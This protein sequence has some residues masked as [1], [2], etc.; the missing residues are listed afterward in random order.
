VTNVSDAGPGSLRAAVAAN[1]DT[2]PDPDTIN[3]A[4][5]LTG[6]TIRLTSGQL[7]LTNTTGPL[8]IEELSGGPPVISGE[9]ASRVF[10]V[11]SG[12]MAEILD[13]TI[14]GG[15]T[16]AGGISNRGT[17]TV[18]SCTLSG[19]RCGS[20]L[21]G[22]GVF[23]SGSLTVT[24]STFSGNISGV[25]GGGIFNDSNGR[26]TVTDSTLSG[27][28]VTNF[29]GGGGGIINSFSATMTIT[30]STITGNR[31]RGAYSVA[32]AASA[33]PTVPR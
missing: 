15:R 24:N 7:T 21:G 9:N 1:A 28:S 32:P 30:N 16:T 5:S 18:T 4:P 14:S 3:F 17:L 12:M 19:N 31:V 20:A 29:T 11:R 25:R 26:L 22:G 23:N 27:N 10:E 6:A 33:T 2:N 8:L 13:L